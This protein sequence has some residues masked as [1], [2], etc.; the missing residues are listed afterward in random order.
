MDTQSVTRHHLD[1]P[2]GRVY[3]EVRGSGP[4]LLVV[5]QPMTSGPFAPLAD[6]LAED[7]TVVTYDPHGVGESTMDDPSQDVTPEVEADD[8]AAIIDAVGGAPA[9]VFG[10]SGGAVA[11]L[12]LVVRHPEKVGTLIAHEPP[13]AELLPDAA[14]IRAAVDQVEDAYRAHGAGAG[15]GGF[16]DLVMHDGPM[17]DA[18]PAPV[19]WPPA[20]GSGD[21]G[22]A[23][24]PSAKR[25]ADDETFFLRM[26][27]P[28]TRYQPPVDALRSAG[29]RIV[30]A[31]GENS[32]EEIAGRS[33]EAL[34]ERLGSLLVR[35]PG[36]HGGFMAD[37]AG[38]AA[39]IRQVSAGSR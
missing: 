20:G 35:F 34:A 5:G 15:W 14:H 9:D 36:D 16:I 31:V 33:A 7:H 37:P 23:P 8:L 19:Q 26:L 17:T 13:V 27:K 22:P 29:P 24:E 39:A 10:S 25:Q 30:V 38:F 21:E 2:G 18:G 32:G 12:A 1:V 28:F 4:L 6:L 3:Y 11:G